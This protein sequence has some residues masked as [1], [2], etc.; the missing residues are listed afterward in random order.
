MPAKSKSQRRLMAMAKYAP[1]KISKKNKGVLD[2]TGKQLSD[3]AST[4]EKGLPKKKGKK[5]A[6]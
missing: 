4:P 6:D 2:M 1:E 3:F 5:Y